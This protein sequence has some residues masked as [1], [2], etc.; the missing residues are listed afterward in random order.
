MS[1]AYSIAVKWKGYS[2]SVVKG[3][4]PMNYD[5]IKGQLNVQMTQIFSALFLKLLLFAS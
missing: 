2:Q 3:E 4:T 5:E 1:A